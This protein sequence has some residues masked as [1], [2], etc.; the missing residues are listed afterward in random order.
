MYSIYIYTYIR[1]P[2]DWRKREK[3]E[4]KRNETATRLDRVARPPGVEVDRLRGVAVELLPERVVEEREVARVLV[5]ALEEANAPPSRQSN[6]T[7]FAVTRRDHPYYAPRHYETRLGERAAIA[8]LQMGSFGCAETRPSVC[9]PTHPDGWLSEP[10][11]TRRHRDSTSALLCRDNTVIRTHA[12]SHDSPNL[13]ER[14][15]ADAAVVARELRGDAGRGGR[16]FGR[17][18]VHDVDG[19][20]EHER[21]AEVLEHAVEPRHVRLG[22]S[23]RFGCI[24]FCR[25]GYWRAFGS[26]WRC[27]PASS[28]RD[29]LAPGGGASSLRRWFACGGRKTEILRSLSLFLSH[30]APRRASG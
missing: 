28:V 3:R 8:T 11:G 26:F 23:V 15:D 18:R 9:A 27:K 12:T 30:C 24:W 20:A 19:E 25:F 21:A 10:R 14:A 16:V 7:L 17:A 6:L 22:G 29:R 2:T 1:H 5:D 4:A 13:G